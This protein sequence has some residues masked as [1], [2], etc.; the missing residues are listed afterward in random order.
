MLS[1]FSLRV[2]FFFRSTVFSKIRFD[3]FLLTFANGMKTRTEIIAI[4][5]LLFIHKMNKYAFYFAQ[6]AFEVEYI[7]LWLYCGP[8]I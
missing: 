6:E 4:D 2:V 7:L 3:N 8:E 1:I 5:Y